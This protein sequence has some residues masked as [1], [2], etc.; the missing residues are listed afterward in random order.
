M[1]THTPE[2]KPKPCNGSGLDIGASSDAPIAVP[3]T[4]M[5]R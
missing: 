1:I 5:T 2:P 3:S 4:L